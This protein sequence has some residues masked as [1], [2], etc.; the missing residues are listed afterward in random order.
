MK[1]GSISDCLLENL[2]LKRPGAPQSCYPQR[3][4]K[5]GDS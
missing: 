3:L 2:A 4:S 5:W 1:E